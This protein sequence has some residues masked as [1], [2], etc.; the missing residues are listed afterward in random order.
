[1]AFASHLVEQVLTQ[2]RAQAEVKRSLAKGQH[3]QRQETRADG[4][5]ASASP[6]KFLN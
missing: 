5:A 1:L 4:G 2:L 3:G 6:P